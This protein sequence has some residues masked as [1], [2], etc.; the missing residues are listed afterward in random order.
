M[1]NRTT[2][3]VLKSGGVWVLASTPADGPTT[4]KLDALGPVAYIVSGDAEHHA[5]LG[6]SRPSPMPCTGG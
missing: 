6:M 2:A 5:F 1:G 3:I 4:A